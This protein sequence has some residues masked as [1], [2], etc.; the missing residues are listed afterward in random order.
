MLDSVPSE[1]S[2]SSIGE[3][4]GSEPIMA[5]P[6]L[7]PDFHIAVEPSPMIEVPAAD[8][9]MPVQTRVHV[10]APKGLLPRFSDVLLA[11]LDCCEPDISVCRCP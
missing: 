2:Y 6:P 7:I 5:S 8:Q 3:T 4:P 10:A 9:R 11:I 1:S